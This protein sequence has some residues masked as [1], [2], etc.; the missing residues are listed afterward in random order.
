VT[1]EPS[2]QPPQRATTETKDRDRKPFL[3]ACSCLCLRIFRVFAVDS[4][5]RLR[6]LHSVFILWLSF[7]AWK[8]VGGLLNQAAT[9]DANSGRE[10]DHAVADS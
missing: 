5:F 2:R 9:R 10:Y 3:A 4:A 1:S 8:A 7:I 6:L